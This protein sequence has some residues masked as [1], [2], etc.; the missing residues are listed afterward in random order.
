MPLVTNSIARRCRTVA[1]MMRSLP[2][3]ILA[4]GRTHRPIFISWKRNVGPRNK[5]GSALGMHGRPFR[6]RRRLQRNRSRERFQGE[7]LSVELREERH[8]QRINGLNCNG[9]E[10][11]CDA[12]RFFRGAFLSTLGSLLQSIVASGISM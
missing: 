9:Q 11:R 5:I 12:Q 10:R 8:L 3:V 7:I 6:P 4:N 2:P 1:L